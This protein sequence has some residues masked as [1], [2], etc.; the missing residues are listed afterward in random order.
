M[1]FP[2]LNSFVKELL[3]FKQLKRMN[4]VLAVL[5]GICIFPLFIAGFALIG[6]IYILAAFLELLHIPAEYLI[7]FTKGTTEELKPAPQTVIYFVCMPLIFTLEAMHAFLYLI[8]GFE[9]FSLSIY[10]QIATLGGMTFA[11]FIHLQRERNGVME[12]SIA[13]SDASMILL[14]ILIAL[15]IYLFYRALNNTS[16]DMSA[17]FVIAFSYRLY[18]VIRKVLFVTLLVLAVLFVIYPIFIYNKKLPKT[19]IVL[20]VFIYL[21]TALLFT[22]TCLIV[23]SK[24]MV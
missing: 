11:P 3:E 15:G 23:V 8:I 1:I 24:I 2:I 18:L 5:I 9:F 7:K 4:K 12:D 16:T 13:N 6:E 17:D 20:R 10:Y 22:T 21:S 14:V 19:G